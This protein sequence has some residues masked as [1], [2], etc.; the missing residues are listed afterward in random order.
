MSHFYSPPH[1][2]ST[3]KFGSSS[4]RKIPLE[5]EEDAQ[6]ERESTIA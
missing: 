2:S 5:E 6:R 4:I 1:W 3:I